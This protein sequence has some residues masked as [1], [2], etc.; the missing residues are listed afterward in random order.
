M[1]NEKGRSNGPSTLTNQ[2]PLRYSQG[3]IPSIA[4]SPEG[5]R[6]ATIPRGKTEELRLAWD[7][8]EGH[9]YLGL[10]VWAKLDEGKWIPTKKGLSIRLHELAELL[11]GLGLAVVKAHA[12][13]AEE[14]SHE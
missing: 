3:A 11:E 8:Y 6:L 9:P 2:S 1:T 4:P 12:L 10:R 13:K 14:G 7:E 5:E